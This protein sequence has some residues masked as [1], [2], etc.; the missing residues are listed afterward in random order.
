M[1]PPVQ[2][3][4]L[5]YSCFPIQIFKTNLPT[6]KNSEQHYIRGY[7]INKR[8]ETKNNVYGNGTER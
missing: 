1:V 4:A 2:S 3:I 5:L 6:K 8:N 7:V